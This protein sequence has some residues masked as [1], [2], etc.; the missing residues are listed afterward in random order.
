[1]HSYSLT[2]TFQKTWISGA[3]HTVQ[4]VKIDQPH[5]WRLLT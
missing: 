3:V 2:H 5:P 1:M 4:L